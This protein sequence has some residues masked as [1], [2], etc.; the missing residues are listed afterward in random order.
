MSKNCIKI[1]FSYSHGINAQKKEIKS[2]K[3]P[4]A[5]NAKKKNCTKRFD[6]KTICKLWYDMASDSQG[7]LMH[8]HTCIACIFFINIYAFACATNCA[9]M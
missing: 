5:K 9:V 1:Q 6:C 4:E 8:I 7:L 3:R 2:Q